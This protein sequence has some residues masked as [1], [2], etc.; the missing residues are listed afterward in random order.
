M[1]EVQPE[2]VAP[3]SEQ[4]KVPPCSLLVKVKVAEVAAVEPLG[5]EAIVVF[6][7]VKITVQSALAALGSTLPEESVA[8]TEK[9]WVASL[10]PE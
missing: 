4:K 3:S 2:A 5:P 8:T 10:R 6:G 1:G 7:G 9:L